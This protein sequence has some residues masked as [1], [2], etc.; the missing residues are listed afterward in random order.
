MKIRI[1]LWAC[2]ALLALMPTG[3]WVPGAVAAEVTAPSVGPAIPFP[4]ELQVTLHEGDSQN[5]RILFPVSPGPGPSGIREASLG[6]SGCPGSRDS[7]G[8]WLQT[9]SSAVMMPAGTGSHSGKAYPASFAWE[10]M[11]FPALQVLV[12]TDDAAS[13]EGPASP[14]DLALRRLAWSY[15]A[16]YDGDF[17]GFESHLSSGK[18]DL[19]LFIST[20]WSPPPSVLSHLDAYVKAGGRLIYQGTAGGWEP[21]SSLWKTLGFAWPDTPSATPETSLS[22]WSFSQPLFVLPEQLPSK[23]L[24]GKN[25]GSFKGYPVEQLDGAVALAGYGDLKDPLHAGIL[26]ANQGRTLALTFHESLPHGDMDGDST[27]DIVELW[28][29]ALGTVAAME[30]SWVSASFDSSQTDEAPARTH[31]LEVNLDAGN[32]EPG[33]YRALLKVEGESQEG[34]IA[35]P[36][37]LTVAD[38]E[39]PALDLGTA[40]G[41]PGETVTVPIT[42]TGNGAR[43]SATSNDIVFNP[44]VFV[45]ATAVVGPAATSAGKDITVES[46]YSGTLRVGIFGMNN[47]EIP[48]GV[49]AYVMLTISDYVYSGSYPLTNQPSASDPDG[50][51]VAVTGTD[52]TVDVKRTYTIVAAAGPHGSMSPAGAVSVEEG[53]SQIFAM[54]PDDGYHIADVWVDYYSVGAVETWTISNVYED[55]RIVAVFEADA[56]GRH[57]VLALAGENGTIDP[58]GLLEVG[59][60]ED[61][62]FTI[63]PNSGYRL[64][65]IK[66]NGQSVS[67]PSGPPYQY[68]MENITTDQTIA[69]TFSVITFPITP[70]VSGTGTGTITPKTRVQV[71]YGGSRTFVVTPA[72][73]SFIKDV[74]VD[75]VSV[76]AVDFYIFENVRKAHTI[77]AEFAKLTYTIISSA[78]IGGKITPL[79]AVSVPYGTNKT[80]TITPSKGYKVLDVILDGK[81]LGIKRKVTFS[82]VTG[83][84]WIVA[85]FG[86]I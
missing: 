29:N 18:W 39:T 52:G 8:R 69:A 83:N 78:S 55:H 20:K 10:S 31:S 79:G 51:L 25:T 66:V 71:P 57:S 2:L 14:V 26:L 49:V 58:S 37:T 27:P 24:G 6:C 3:V 36:I 50:A 75:G 19:I 53:G 86:K 73:G 65:D 63:T 80:Y 15:V 74:K 40:M 84:H 61:I 54:T 85:I 34:T 28:C 59:N 44:Y 7:Y 60:G 68:K 82:K 43:I 41:I 22:F 70:G 81:S 16:H 45:N 48:D 62:T 1:T 35:F 67:L 76:G 17:Q 5:R 47:T 42:L 11:Q 33:I 12:Y 38:G 56:L 23:G 30:V 77:N 4:Q 9:P 13:A 64:S 72:E 32:L 46:P 21:Q